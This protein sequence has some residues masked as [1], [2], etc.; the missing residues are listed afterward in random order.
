MNDR[1]TFIGAIIAFFVGLLL[2]Q[3]EKAPEPGRFTKTFGG[4]TAWHV[5]SQSRD[6]K[7]LNE[8]RDPI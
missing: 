4:R 2:G 7:P 5:R 3:Q 6:V 8:L 1:R